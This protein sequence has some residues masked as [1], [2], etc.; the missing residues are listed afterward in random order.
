MGLPNFK[1]CPLTVI[2][3]LT[4]SFPEGKKANIQGGW[5]EGGNGREVE[6]RQENAATGPELGS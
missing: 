3:S 1:S 5:E 6:G 2:T 4:L